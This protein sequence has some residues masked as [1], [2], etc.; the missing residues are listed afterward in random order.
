MPRAL[1]RAELSV[2]LLIDFQQRLIPAI[3]SGDEIVAQASRL[4]R[5]ARVLD[6]PMVATEQLPDRLGPTV[7]AL[8]GLAAATIPKA[9]FDACRDEAVSAALPRSRPM[10]A[11]TGCEAHVCVMQTAFGLLDAGLQVAVVRDAVGSRRLESKETALA[12]LANAG[13]EIVTAEMAIFE[14]LGSAERQ[15]FREVLALIK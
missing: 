9:T 3:E 13:A 8:R 5:A 7:A 15:E 1:L 10:V 14:W 2:L 11:V 6:V 4:A 12:R